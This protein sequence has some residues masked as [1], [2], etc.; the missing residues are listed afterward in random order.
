M[1]K[2]WISISAIA[3]LFGVI[4]SGI[5]YYN[6]NAEI[7]NERVIRTLETTDHHSWL[8]RGYSEFK[9]QGTTYQGPLYFGPF[10]C[11]SVVIY[12]QGFENKYNWK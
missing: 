1:D 8:F 10:P 5:S 3:P 6:N 12:K 2:L 4:M 9:Y 11:D 7:E